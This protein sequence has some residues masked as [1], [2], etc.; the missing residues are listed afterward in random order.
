MRDL[1]VY[2]ELGIS[3][4]TLILTGVF[5]ALGWSAQTWELN[6]LS[7]RVS[8]HCGVLDV[9]KVTNLFFEFPSTL[10]TQ[11]VLLGF[12]LWTTLRSESP[13]KA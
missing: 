5:F 3:D 9:V 8:Y 13:T 12:E 7:R 2:Q 6:S 10:G 4:V 11:H 1:C